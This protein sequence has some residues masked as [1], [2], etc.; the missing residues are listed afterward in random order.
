LKKKRP[1]TILEDGVGD[2]LAARDIKE[3]IKNSTVYDSTNKPVFLSKSDLPH[4]TGIT[5]KASKNTKFEKKQGTLNEVH[6][7]MGEF[8]VPKK[9]VDLIISTYGSIHYTAFPLLQDHLLKF[10]HALKKE[11]LMLAV[12]DPSSRTNANIV[13]MAQWNR[14]I[15][16]I[17]Q[18][19][20]PI[21]RKFAKMGFKAKIFENESNQFVIIVQRLR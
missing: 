13:D 12:F 14:E 18:N 5:L 11:G 6:Q 4:I 8:F 9:P 17:R 10:V 1:L 2:G 20:T 7:T 16:Y 15:K 3:Y 21:E 19:T